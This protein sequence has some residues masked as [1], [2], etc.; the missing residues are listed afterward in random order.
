VRLF[1]G[2]AAFST[3]EMKPPASKQLQ[4][5]ENKKRKLTAYLE[6][7]KLN[8]KDREVSRKLFLHIIYLFYS[9]FKYSDIF[10]PFCYNKKHEYV[11]I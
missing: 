4:R 9:Q 7:A 8:D 2:V 1:E 3:T 6:I 11:L 5:V 10:C